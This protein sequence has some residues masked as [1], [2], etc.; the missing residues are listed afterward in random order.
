M[1]VM[2][3]RTCILK[4]DISSLSDGW[5]KYLEKVTDLSDSNQNVN[6]RCISK[7]NFTELKIYL[8]NSIEKLSRR[9]YLCCQHSY[10]KISAENIISNYV[11]L[12]RL[13]NN[14]FCYYPRVLPKVNDAKIFK[15]PV[16][17]FY[18]LRSQIICILAHLTGAFKII[19]I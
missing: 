2:H 15:N 16:V 1:S 8:S 7:V 9:N 3:R 4:A 19:L 12:L 6:T 11:L 17:L 13:V 10:L 5:P 18:T 14:F